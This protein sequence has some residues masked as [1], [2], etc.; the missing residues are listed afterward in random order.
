MGTT[1]TLPSADGKNRNQTKGEKE[2]LFK[3]WMEISK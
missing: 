2:N 3:A 1:G